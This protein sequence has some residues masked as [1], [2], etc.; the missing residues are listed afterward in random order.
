MVAETLSSTTLAPRRKVTFLRVII[1]EFRKK[2]TRAGRV[3][4]RSW[5]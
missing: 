5:S 3:A 4:V 1:P 2:R